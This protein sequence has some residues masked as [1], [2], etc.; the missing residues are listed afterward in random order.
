MG[1]AQ[2]LTELIL[3]MELFILTPKVSHL[4]ITSPEIVGR[5][6]NKEIIFDFQNIKWQVTGRTCWR[7]REIWRERERNRLLL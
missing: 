6:L 4:D 7:D 5:V 2:S 1:T 3:L